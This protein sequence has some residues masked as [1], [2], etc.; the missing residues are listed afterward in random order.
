M[1]H[2]TRNTKH[3]FDVL[4]VGGGMVGSVLSVA[5]ARAGFDVGL[6]EARRP[7][8]FDAEG[9]YDLRVS[10][11]APG[12]RRLLEN[13]G[14]WESIAARRVSPYRGMR[15][16]DAGGKALLEFEHTAL[17]LPELGH[18]VENNLIV[19][20]AWAN[21]GNVRVFCPAMLESLKVAADAATVTLD[22]GQRLSAALVV[23]AEGAN[24]PVRRM[25]AIPTVGWPYRQRCTV[26]SVTPEKPHRAIAWQR[27]TPTGPVAFLPLA[28]GR[29][30]LAWHA[31]D[32]LADELAE[33]DD[34]AFCERLTE[35]SGGVL[36]EI[37][38]VGARGAF[39]LRLQHAVDYVRERIALIGDAAHVVHPMAGQGVNLGLLDVATLADVLERGRERG[40]DPGDP[41]L[42]RR[43]QRPRKVEN[44]AMLAATDAFKH[45]FGN[46]H[47]VSAYLRDRAIAAADD[48]APIKQ[49][50]IRHA[51][52]LAPPPGGE[53]PR[54]L[55]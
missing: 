11:I 9:D 36:G 40:R 19:D 22:D 34:A 1:K 4:I 55:R 39:P 47:P 26:G 29:C 50:M 3:D 45:V 37:R 6:V 46:R 38:A 27:F 2:E 30:S 8:A 35:A 41:A 14:L 33:L 25:A 44:I 31:D 18:I 15:V 17:G 23:G 54:L 49:T 7:P 5:L 10:A 43:Y 32:P 53:L 24:S 20:A 16:W 48:L 28:D 21:L 12:P 42:L 52:G 51:A 13:L